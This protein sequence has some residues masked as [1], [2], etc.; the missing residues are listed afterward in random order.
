VIEGR[1][2]DSL[3]V[4]NLKRRVNRT[5]VIQE[6]NHTVQIEGENMKI[7]WRY[8]GYC[9]AARASSM[10]FSVDSD[11]ATTF[12]ELNCVAYDLGNDPDKKRE[13]R[14]LLIGTEGISK[15]ISVPFL[16]PVEAHQAFGVLLSCTLPRCVRA[17]TGYYT[18][19][20]SFAQDRV[21]RCEVRI[22]FV[23]STPTWVRVYECIP[24]RAPVL[25][26]SLTASSQELQGCEYA[27]VTEDIA[28]R[29]ARVYLFHRDAV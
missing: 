29:S 4:A 25:L 1:S 10:E 5:F 14:P 18:S 16:E 8:S 22:T 6:A 23:G 19:T 12:A 21:R 17:G 7:T 26:K 28:G 15:K 9:R 11:S 24:R 13:I 20:L 3:N 2:I 27:D